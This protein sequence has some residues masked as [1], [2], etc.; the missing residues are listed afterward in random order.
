[1]VLSSISVIEKSVTI[2]IGLPEQKACLPSAV[3]AGGLCEYKN[4]LKT[5][6]TKTT[7]LFLNLR[8]FFFLIINLCLFSYFCNKAQFNTSIV[9]KL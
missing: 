4:V 6:K 5:N 2:F 9:N 8:D 1:M 3:I 7:I